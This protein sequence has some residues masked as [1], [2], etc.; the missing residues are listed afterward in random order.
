MKKAMTRRQQ[1]KALRKIVGDI[2]RPAITNLQSTPLTADW[3]WLELRA[4]LLFHMTYET[5]VDF[6]KLK[7]KLRFGSNGYSAAL[8]TVQKW[9]RTH[10]VTTFMPE[11]QKKPVDPLVRMARAAKRKLAKEKS[12]GNP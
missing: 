1:E 10:S 6:Q 2:L 7:A 3:H 4:L 9:E 8:K 12:D 5:N 11:P